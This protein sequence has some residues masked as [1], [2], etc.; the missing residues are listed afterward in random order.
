[1]L[2]FVG[3]HGAEYG[4]CA[5]VGNLATDI[6]HGGVHRVRERIPGIA[7]NDKLSLLCH[8]TSHVTAAASYNDQATLH[9]HSESGSRITMDYHCSAA[10]SRCG[11]TARISMH[12]H[13]AAVITGTSGN[14]NASILQDRDCEVVT[15]PWIP[16]R[17]LR[18]HFGD[19][20]AD[21]G[22]NLACA[23]PGGIYLCHTCTSLA[24]ASRTT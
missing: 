12:P 6:A 1:M 18:P 19:G 4:V 17:D 20:L 2:D 8:E 21:S 3:L 10:K 16:Q 23:A 13:R 5:E 7:A 14:S 22:V 9:R 15:C 11:A 24:C